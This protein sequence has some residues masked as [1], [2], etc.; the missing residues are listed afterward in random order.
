MV[1]SEDELQN[2]I[3]EVRKHVEL[4]QQKLSI[5]RQIL[6]N[7]ESIQKRAKQVP[8]TTGGYDIV[9]E[10]PNDEKNFKAM[11]QQQRD[12]IFTI[13]KTKFESLQGG[14]SV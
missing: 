3:V 11:S 5:L 7:F 2:M 4:Q 14:L 10:M 12:E 9:Y 1:F 13:N 8:N 6:Q